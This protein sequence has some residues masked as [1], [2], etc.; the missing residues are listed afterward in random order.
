VE[1]VP[2]Q[3]IQ[4][5]AVADTLL[6]SGLSDRDQLHIHSIDISEPVVR[7]LT[8]VSNGSVA[9]LFV[10]PGLAEHS[11][12]RLADDYRA[13]VQGFGAHIGKA[14]SSTPSLARGRQIREIALHPTIGSRFTAAR[15]NVVT[16]RYLTKTFDAV[17]VTNVFPY[18]SDAELA[19]ALSNLSHMVRRGGYLVHNEPR[20]SLPLLAAAAGFEPVHARG[21]GLAWGPSG[22]ISDT[23]W[24]HRRP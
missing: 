19:L 4:P 6:A 9:R 17:I 23:I 22:A 12:R 14:L 15:M 18:F 21:V 7:Y 5:F 20:A 16:E 13:Y 10:A 11:E 3:S 1:E 8:A 2:P 24:I